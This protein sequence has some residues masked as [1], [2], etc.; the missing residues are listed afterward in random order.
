VSGRR[1]A[2]GYRAKVIAV[3][4]S[5][6]AALL[7]AIASVL[8]HRSAV[9][10]PVRHSMRPGLLAHLAVQPVWLAGI[11]ADGL[12]FVMQFIALG[13]GPLVV[14]Q[15][16]LVTGLLFA[17]P[18]GAVVSGG[19]VHGG[20][21]WAAG[22]VVVG[23]AL[24]LGAANPGTGR[25]DMAPISWLI[26]GLATLVPVGIL[27]LAAGR[28][29]G[30][31]PALL[32]TAA[33]VVYGLTA[34]LAK[35]SAHLLG[36]GVGHFAGS[37]QPWALIPG[38]ILGMVL[39]QSAFQAGTLKASLPLLTAVDPLV[40]IVIGI[41]AFHEQVSQHPLGVALEISAGAVLV[42]GVLALGRSPL[43]ALDDEGPASEGVAA[44]AGQ[45][46]GSERSAHGGHR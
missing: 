3:V 21:L 12:A 7:Y 42:L 1:A 32:A 40:S 22:A 19:R 30:A 2:A 45:T 24:L 26:L 33:G 41:V 34:A 46:P 15:P 8:Q 31:R 16:L 14:V 37:W 9:A 25:Q 44:G 4:A 43:I 13:H 11:A 39:C 36:R 18:L 17:L 6:L 29:R 35:T 38:G 28:W 5:L 20:E 23:L 10:A 27:C